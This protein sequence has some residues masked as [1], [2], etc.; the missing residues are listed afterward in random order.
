MGFGTTF[1][2]PR[3]V[4]IAVE[5]VKELEAAHGLSIEAIIADGTGG[6]VADIEFNVDPNFNE[7]FTLNGDE[8]TLTLRLT[9]TSSV[10]TSV[11]LTFSGNI[12]KADTFDSGTESNPYFLIDPNSTKDVTLSRGSGAPSG[13]DPAVDC[14]I[15]YP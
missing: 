5:Q 9:N 6:G 10:A 15:T 11:E 3:Y 13:S 4:N 2:G 14:T 7:P 8:G 12:L 1:G